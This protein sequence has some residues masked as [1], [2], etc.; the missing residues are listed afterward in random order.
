MALDGV[1]Y[2]Q[3]KNKRS[4]SAVDFAVR[5]ITVVW[6]LL[7][8]SW[9]SLHC[10]AGSDA[11]GDSSGCGGSGGGVLAV[12]VAV[13]LLYIL[14]RSLCFPPPVVLLALLASLVV[15]VLLHVAVIICGGKW[16]RQALC[17]VQNMTIR[18]AKRKRKA[19]KP[20]LKLYI[21]DYQYTP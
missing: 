20:G 2:S 12:A 6:L 13:V 16:W 9:K 14:L 19:A 7:P 10:F 11:G 1:A 8:F 3:K 21:H 18:K 4:P 17:N 5:I 15:L